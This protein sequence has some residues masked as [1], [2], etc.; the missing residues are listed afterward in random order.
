[1]RTSLI[2]V[3]SR[4]GN[5]ADGH[6]VERSTVLPTALPRAAAVGAYHFWVPEPHR[7]PEYTA[8]VT[9]PVGAPMRVTFVGD[10]LDHGLDG[11]YPTGGVA[12]ASEPWSLARATRPSPGCVV[13]W[14]WYRGFSGQESWGCGQ[15]SA[16]EHDGGIG[17]NTR[18][19]CMRRWP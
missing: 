4:I 3:G 17:Q 10:S 11:I 1:V 2:R 15:R 14:P 8:T 19:R 5:P 18:T 16:V 7:D 12:R 13:T 6:H 9:V